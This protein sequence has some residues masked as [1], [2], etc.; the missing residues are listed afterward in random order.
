MKNYK[1][2]IKFTI[3]F[4]LLLCAIFSFVG[5][6][7]K[8]CA[9]DIQ[10]MIIEGESKIEI[11][12]DYCLL[13]FNIKA[14]EQDFEGGQKKISDTITEIKEK[15]SEI[16]ENNVVYITYN[17]CYPVYNESLVTYDF[18][19]SFNVKSNSIN[20][21]DKII[22]TVGQLGQIS[23]YGTEFKIDNTQN[24]YLEALKLAKEDAINRAKNFN[25]DSELKAIVGTNVYSY[26][27]YEKN[28]KIIIEA[29]VKGIFVNSKTNE[30]IIETEKDLSKSISN[31]S[32]C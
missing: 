15:I 5:N 18:S 29:R 11:S 2:K 28:G 9:E 23:Y 7:N 30:E 20:N 8:V 14:K 17:S 1:K 4:A 22:K 3:I 21:C 16:D 10:M 12:A 25:Q 26:S 19:C 13:S 6:N 31:K 32:Y 27:S 24:K